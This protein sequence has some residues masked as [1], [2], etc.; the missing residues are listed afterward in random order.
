MP[1]RRLHPRFALRGQA[2]V[3]FRSWPIFK[4]LYTGNIS[5]GGMSLELG[6][7]PKVGERLLVR[8]VLPNQWSVQLQAIVRHTSVLAAPSSAT[9]VARYTVGVEFL[10]LDEEKRAQIEKT[11]KAAVG[12][13]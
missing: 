13:L 10:D 2:E 5:K 11:I 6:E 9:F 3:Q 12:T 7:E 1:E 8:L 4:L